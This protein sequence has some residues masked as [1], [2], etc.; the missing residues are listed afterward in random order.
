[1]R[2]RRARPRAPG[3]QRD[4]APPGLTVSLSLSLSLSLTLA[5]TLTLTFTPTRSASRR[6]CTP[7]ARSGAA[8]LPWSRSEGSRAAEPT[9]PCDAHELRSISAEVLSSQLGE[10]DGVGELSHAQSA[11]YA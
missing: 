1:M 9:A 2:R 4:G 3:Q 8:W 6:R 7:C 5:L 11:S 10:R